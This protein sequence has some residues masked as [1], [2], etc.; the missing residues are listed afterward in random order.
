[1]CPQSG[2]YRN[3]NAPIPTDLDASALAVPDFAPW[4]LQ[5][6]GIAD[7]SL[8]SQVLI[9]TS[10]DSVDQIT[11]SDSGG[12]LVSVQ[13][14]ILM[15]DGELEA[16]PPEGYTPLRIDDTAI[17]WQDAGTPDVSAQVLLA[18][19]SA[20]AA[21]EEKAKPGAAVL[22]S[23]DW[24]REFGQGLAPENRIRKPLLAM[25]YAA[26]WSGTTRPPSPKRSRTA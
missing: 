5:I 23:L 6:R 9:A 16:D 7:P 18:M 13:K 11:F 21:A 17:R 1:L 2:V 3:Y 12:S 25:G 4:R 20:P 14:F 10:V 19:A 8:V 24:I 26:R 15:P 22:Q